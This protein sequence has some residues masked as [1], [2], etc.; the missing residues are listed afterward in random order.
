MDALQA[1]GVALASATSEEEVA[2]AVAEHLVDALEQGGGSIVAVVRGDHL[3]IIGSRGLRAGAA[4]QWRRLP[5]DAH[6]P[7]CDA[8]RTGEAIWLGD[9]ATFLARYPQPVN[10][11]PEDLVQA[12]VAVPLS[13]RDECLGALGLSFRAPREFEESERGTILTFARMC[14]QALDRVRQHAA[15]KRETARLSVLVDAAK[16]FA[17]TGV[18]FDVRLGKVA[19]KFAEVVGESCAVWLLS[20]DERFVDPVAMHHRSEELGRIARET[21]A[22]RRFSSSEGPVSWVTKAGGP[23]RFDAEEIARRVDLAAPPYRRLA[24][25]WTPSTLAAVPLV[26]RGRVVGALSMTRAISE[27]P[28]GEDDLRLLMALADHVSLAYEAERAR[29]RA[30]LLSDLASALA[31]PL[32]LDE[33]L[34]VLAARVVPALADGLTLDLVEPDGALRQALVHHVDPVVRD[35]I[36]RMRLQFG[37]LADEGLPS[38]LAGHRQRTVLVQRAELERMASSPEHLEA[39]RQTKTASATIA[40]LVARGRLIGVLAFNRGDGRSP[41]DQGDLALCADLAARV[42]VGI[43]NLRLLAETQ[44][45]VRLR[46]QFLSI[47]S[48]ELKTPVTALLLQLDA[49]RRALRAAGAEDAAGPWPDRIGR[50]T[51]RLTRLVDDLLDVSRIESGRM[52][53]DLDPCDLGELVDEIVAR[54][55]EHGNARISV[56]SEGRVVGQWDRARLDQVVTNLI[57]NALKYGGGTPVLIAIASDGARARLSVHDEGKGVPLADQSRI[58]EAFERGSNTKHGGGFGLGL[59]IVKSL[60]DAHSGSVHVESE[61]GR[62]TTFVVELPLVGPTRSTP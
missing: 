17:E 14:A 29:G 39:I 25:H 43:D 6:L 28:Y 48:H 31:E 49:L 4:V 61:P 9:R 12:V 13:N 38:V 22:A 46:D 18:G 60:V 54:T 24:A 62:G 1:L 21:F 7:A 15:A 57:V 50:Q 55:Q 59:F 3:E 34:A 47:A 35:H 37:H 53:L 20:E 2:A 42:A 44:A 30:A 33:L 10:A 16:I 45:A 56:Q 23:V 52:R 51:R 26:S 36:A 8:V 32:Q 27:V 40:P 11:A 58:F 41:F 19:Q 5:L